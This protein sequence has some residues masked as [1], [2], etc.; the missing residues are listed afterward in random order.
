MSIDTSRSECRPEDRDAL[1]NQITFRGGF[2]KLDSTISAFR[3]RLKSEFEELTKRK[4][5][6]F[7]CSGYKTKDDKAG[8]WLKRE[9]RDT[10]ED[11]TTTTIAWEQDVTWQTAM[12][13]VGRQFSAAPPEAFPLG[14]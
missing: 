10:D 13:R 6:S 2:V 7:F 8:D 1:V 11:T 4:H 5:Q 3:T 9:D 12:K 14:N